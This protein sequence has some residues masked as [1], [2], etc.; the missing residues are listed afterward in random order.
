MRA[1]TAHAVI[2]L[3][4]VAG[5]G[6]SIFAAYESTHPGVEGVC[7]INSYISCSKIDNSG[8]T[9]TLGIQDFYWGIAGFV[10]M[11]ALDLPLYRSWNRRLLETL[12]AISFAGVLLTVYLA[13]IEFAVIQGLCVICLGAYLSNAVVLAFLVYLVR[14][15]RAERAA[16]ARA[17]SPTASG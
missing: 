4:L 11:L 16:A 8:Q 6:F 17:D 14:L 3:G 2:L 15:G 10:V 1:E 5:L 9:T 12:T 13:Y 7:T